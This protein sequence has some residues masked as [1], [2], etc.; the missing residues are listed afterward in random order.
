MFIL[1]L[2]IFAALIKISK[3]LTKSNFN[4]ELNKIFD[5]L[6]VVRITINTEQWHMVGG[7]QWKSDAIK[8]IM[9]QQNF[10]KSFLKL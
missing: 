6:G 10:L 4:E 2:I 8:K 9:M 5:Y 3:P 7:W 1:F